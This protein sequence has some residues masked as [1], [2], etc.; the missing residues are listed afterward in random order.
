MKEH[1]QLIGMLHLP[2]LP[3]TPRSQLDPGRIVDAVLAEARILTEAGFDALL[4]ENMHDLPY[5]NADVG[6]EIVAMMTRIGVAV[7]S[8]TKLPL[9]VQVLA[10][11][12]HAALAVAQACDAAFIRAENY[13][14]AHVADEGLMPVADAG[15]LLRY[16]RLIGAEAVTVYA[17]IKKKHAAH[18]LT[19]DV[20]LPDAA[21][22]AAFCGADGIIVTGNATGTAVDPA[23][24]ATVREAVDC[25][26]L[27][28]SGVTPSNLPDLWPHADGFIIG[29]SLKRDS[30]WSNPLD[31]DRIRALMTAAQALRN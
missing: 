19:A 15:P 23:Q 7:R 1:K 22:T 13:T 14:Y 20:A 21:R 17:D 3:G 6:P 27:V 18:A 16:R 25:R 29:S 10:A 4:L 26:V 8:E 12:N 5:L 9:G 31:T 24:L 30:R 11:A 2:A 28:G